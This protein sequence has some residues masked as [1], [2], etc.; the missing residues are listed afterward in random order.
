NDGVNNGID[1]NPQNVQAKTVI[2]VMRQIGNPSNIVRNYEKVLSM[3]EFMSES[4]YI[5]LLKEADKQ[6]VAYRDLL[7][8]KLNP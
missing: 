1:I 4:D 8:D 7:T 6:L 5:Q 3:S 2:S